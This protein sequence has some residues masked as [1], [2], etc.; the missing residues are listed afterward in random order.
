[1]RSLTV[2]ESNFITGGNMEVSQFSELAFEGF[3]DDARRTGTFRS[4]HE[5]WMFF[6]LLDDFVA[7][8]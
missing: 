8:L 2:L 5:R 7:P 1:L 3:K 4:L 6:Q